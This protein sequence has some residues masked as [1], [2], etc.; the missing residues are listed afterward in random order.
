MINGAALASSSRA[1][2]FE[3]KA[4]TLPV[5]TQLARVMTSGGGAASSVRTIAVVERKPP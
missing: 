4:L 1:S 3:K 2:G 5:G